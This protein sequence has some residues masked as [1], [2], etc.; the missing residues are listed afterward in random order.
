MKHFL[1]ASTAL[2]TAGLIGGLASGAQ[3]AERIQVRVS[4][5]HQQWGVASFQD[6]D[7]TDNVDVD[8]TLVDQKHNSEICFVGETKLDNGI[9]VGINV[10]LEANSEADQI[11]ESYLFLTSPD[12]GQILL[13]DENSAAYLLAVVAPDGGISLNQGDTT[14]MPNDGAWFLLPT[15]FAANNTFIN[16]TLIRPND[17]DSGKFTYFSPRFGGVQVGFSYI[18]QYEAGG[19]QN[20]SL[21][22]TQTGDGRVAAGNVNSLHDGFSGGLNYKG[23]FSGVGIQASAGIQTGETTNT[24]SDRANDDLLAYSGGVQV[25]FAG[26]TV[27]GSYASMN[28]DRTATTRFNSHGYDVGAAYATGPYTVGLTYQRG[29]SQGIRG[30][31]QTNSLDQI[32]L[33][34][35][36]QMG[37]GVRLVGGVFVYD[38]DGEKGGANIENNNGWGLASGLKLSF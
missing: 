27:G 16:G 15:S 28:G 30:N 17:D 4:G 13:G 10:Q 24:T 35:G 9:T 38:A 31:N 18:P 29:E 33:S 26:F 36:Y 23:E 14:A 2:V 1:Y 5:Y 22:G 19:D 11:D 21:L 32:V 8:T 7:R 34:G 20:S 37:P 12:F 6:V 3:A 25:A